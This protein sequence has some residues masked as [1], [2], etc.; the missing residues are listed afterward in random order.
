ML[1]GTLVLGVLGRARR[2]CIVDLLSPV[3]TDARRVGTFAR[4]NAR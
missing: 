1:A 4:V 2:R 3:N